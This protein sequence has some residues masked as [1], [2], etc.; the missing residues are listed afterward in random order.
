VAAR[1]AAVEAL[2]LA[3]RA[4]AAELGEG[5]KRFEEIEVCYFRRFAAGAKGGLGSLVGEGARAPAAGWG[6]AARGEEE[7]ARARP[8]TSLPPPHLSQAV[9]DLFI[10]Q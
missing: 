2:L 6:R 4:V 10:S 8:H 5:A 3:D 1:E 9:L 7:E